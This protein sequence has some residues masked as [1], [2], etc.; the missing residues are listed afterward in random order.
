MT[1]N[2]PAL[3]YHGGKWR[4]APWIIEHLPDDHECYVEP[5]GGAASVLLTKRPSPIEVYNDLDSEVVN[6][7]RVLRERTEDLQRAVLL[8]PY[9]REEQQGAYEID[10]ADELE[11]ARKFFVIAWQSRG[12]S[13]GNWRT[14]W[15][16]MR[17]R[18]LRGQTPTDDWRGVDRLLE[19]AAR[20]RD[21]AIEHDDA[22]KVIKRF[23]GPNT[24]FYC[25]PP[26]VRETRSV[27]WSEKAYRHEMTDEDHRALAERL[28]SVRAMVVLSGYHSALYD[29]LYGDW[30]TV[31]RSVATDG[32]TGRIGSATEVLWLSPRTAAAVRQRPLVELEASC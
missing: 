27:R 30:P 23:D 9:A 15:R 7:F 6:F 14:G 24:L 8:T 10:G 17:V 13:R 4:L 32:S 2:R 28:R 19:L 29:E 11:R 18:T 20:L 16:F 26:Y 3:R 12:A 1:I 22:L 31:Q 5:F 21:V 25:D